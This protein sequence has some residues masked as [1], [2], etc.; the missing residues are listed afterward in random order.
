MGARLPMG[1]RPSRSRRDAERTLTIPTPSQ[2]VGPFFGFAMPFQGDAHAVAPGSDGAVRIE[3][4]VFDGAGEPVP[5]AVVEIS[6]GGQFARCGTDR[7]GAC[8]FSVHKAP[9]VDVPG[10]AR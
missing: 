7:E 3:G 5:D 6:D 1:H 8:H 4:Q 2:T 9:S 10:S